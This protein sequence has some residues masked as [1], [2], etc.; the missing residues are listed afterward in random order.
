MT[1]RYSGKRIFYLDILRAIAILGVI[2]CHTS[3]MYPTTYASLKVAIPSLM[4]IVG[5]V[6]VP[7]FFMLSGALLLNRDYDLKGFFKKRYSRILYP[8][9]FW[10]AITSIAV[11]FLI[12]PNEVIKI[13]FAQ[14]R[15]TWFVWTIAGIYLFIP[16]IN[17]FIKEFD[18]TGVK[19]I[20]AIWLFT[21]ILKT[22]KMYPLARLELSYFAGFIG[23]FVLGYY[24]YNS[25]FKINK[26]VLSF[27]GLVLFVVFTL[28]T[29]IIRSNGI[30]GLETSYQSIFVLLASIGVFLIFKGISEHSEKSSS[31][32]SRIHLKLQNGRIGEFIFLLSTCSYGMYFANSFIL[33]FVK[34]LHITSLKWLP[35][36]YIGVVLGSLLLVLLINKIEFMK[37]FSGAS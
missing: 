16:I 12:G 30:G 34:Q 1:N 37:R 25:D 31:I 26:L 9:I 13:I 29:F 24:L 11:Y 7:L 17:S 32:V 36:M 8:A 4:N 22:F 19:Y 35:V 15:Y 21:I 18:M 14:N 2:A 3:K 23:Y 28:L 5:L 27:M 10:I 33:K 6:G 20:L